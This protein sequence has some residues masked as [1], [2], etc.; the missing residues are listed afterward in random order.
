MPETITDTTIN[1]DN[2]SPDP[3][4][5]KVRSELMAKVTATLGRVPFVED[6]VAAYL[7]AI[8]PETP[9]RVKAILLGALVYFIVPIDAIPDVILGL[10][11]T[12][13]AAV[14]WLAYRQVKNY[15]KPHHVEEAQRRLG[16][17]RGETREET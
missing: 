14:F 4:E 12:D 11:F 8:D 17:L 1:M 16:N 9:R 13:D 15:I 7:C 10:G 2:S 5:R 6:L 3:K